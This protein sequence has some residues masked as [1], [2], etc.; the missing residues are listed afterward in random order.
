MLRPDTSSTPNPLLDTL[1]RAEYRMPSED[2]QQTDI[3]KL[4][5]GFCRKESL[6]VLGGVNKTE[7]NL[8]NSTRHSLTVFSS[9][10]HILAG[11]SKRENRQQKVKVCWKIPKHNTL[12][13]ATV[14][15]QCERT[16][17]KKSKYAAEY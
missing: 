7:P 4:E 3:S 10:N 16:G 11:K 13:P 1:F 9:L 5:L 2:C 15:S 6:K 14:Q 12:I 8:N 17:N